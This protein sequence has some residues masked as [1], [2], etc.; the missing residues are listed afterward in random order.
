VSL[1]ASVLRA[2][3]DNFPDYAIYASTDNDLLI[4]AGDAATLAQPLADVFSE[5][6]LAKELRTVHVQNLAD[7]QIRKIA[8]RATFHPLVQSFPVPANSDYYPYL[9]LNAAR[10]R[11]LQ[12]GA[13]DLSGLN[14]AS[15]P[16]I[17]MLEGG[18]TLP[19]VSLDGADYFNRIEQIRRAQYIRDTYLKPNPPEPL[20]MPR[21]L[22]KDLELAS[23][24]ALDCWDPATHGVW[25]HSLFQ[26]AIAVNPFLAPEETG[27]I[28]RRFETAGCYA[29]LPQPYKLWIALFKAI[30]ARDA[31]NMASLAEQLFATPSD[32]PAESRRYLL[33]AAMT[34][35][36]AQNKPAAA[37]RAWERYSPQ[38]ARDERSQLILRLLYAKA[39]GGKAPPN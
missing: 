16:V 21:A 15:V 30:G 9:D 23:L 38:I 32:L 36:L 3:G 25:L 13:G 18:N 5:A 28:W 1:V 37:A 29:S 2:L 12:Q 39:T 14:T 31:A 4:V 17:A 33:T 7:L 8:T 27:A 19:Q 24:R 35:Y 6:G 11:F 22:Q 26:V 34:G 20:A 10:Y